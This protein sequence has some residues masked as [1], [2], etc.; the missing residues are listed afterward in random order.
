MPRPDHL[1][2][3]LVPDHAARCERLLAALADA[4]EAQIAARLPPGA[5]RYAPCAACA[6]GITAPCA[7]CGRPADRPA[8]ARPATA[9]REDR[10]SDWERDEDARDECWQR[11]IAEARGK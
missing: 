8:A 9:P 11:R 5:V 3:A 6:R 4:Y 2:A 1:S 10:R 7:A